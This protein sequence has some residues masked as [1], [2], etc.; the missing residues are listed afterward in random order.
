M[1]KIAVIGGGKIGEALIAGLIAGGVPPKDIHVANRRPERGKELVEAYG[2]IDFVDHQQATDGTDVVFLCVKPKDTVPVLT[3]LADFIDNNESDTAVIS[4]AAGV[5]LKQ[6][7]DAVSAGTPVVRV[8]PNTPMLVGEGMNVVVPGRFVSEEQLDSIVELL[9]MVGDVVV[10]EETHMDAV[11]ALSGSAPAYIFLVAEAMVDAG[12]SLGL[13][14]DLAKR[15]TVGAVSGAGAMLS[16]PDAE[17]Y[18][19]RSHVASPGGT[20]SAAIR[21]LEEGG[22]RAAMYRATEA[23]A[24]RSRE[25]GQG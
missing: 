14:R 13:S 4:M 2:I 10:T 7:E 15:L 6:L 3:D 18:E 8:M 24:R 12:V 9:G 1:P 16:Q 23:S 20:T 19:L 17:P 5:T 22:I 25:L 21:A 11:T